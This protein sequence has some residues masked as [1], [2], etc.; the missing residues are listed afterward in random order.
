MVVSVTSLPISIDPLVGAG[1]YQFR[2]IALDLAGR[3]IGIF[4]EARSIIIPAT[5]PDAPPPLGSTLTI[6][7]ARARV[8]D[9]ITFTISGTSEEMAVLA[10]SRTN[11]GAT[12]R[13]QSLLLGP[14]LG[15]GFTCRLAGPGACSQ[16]FSIPPSLSG[17]FFFQAARSSDSAFASG[18]FSLTNG[19][20][21]T[22]Q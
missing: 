15:V 1:T 7:Q 18:T 6:S 19:S 16:S 11:A 14:D 21:T 10:F 13:G 20:C 17:T 12:F 2:V 8:G 5:C 4:S 9:V 3:P 22:I